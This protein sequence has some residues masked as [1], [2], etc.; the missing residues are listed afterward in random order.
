MTLT[1]FLQEKAKD[2]SQRDR[3][4]LREE[5]VGAVNRLIGQ[6]QAWLREADRLGVLTMWTEEIEI[7]EERLGAYRVPRLH[8][9][10]NATE[11]KVIPVARFNAGIIY[12]GEGK[13]ER[14]DGRIDLLGI[15]MRY[16][17]YRVLGSEERWY[18][19]DEKYASRLLDRERFEAIMKEMLS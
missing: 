3:W 1:E 8:V 12:E 6:F 9:R 14:K 2:E 7:L 4:R 11:V 5:W 15:G 13:G 16:I 18:A 19:L 10:L 17:L